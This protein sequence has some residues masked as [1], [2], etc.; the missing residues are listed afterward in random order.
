MNESNQ[1]HKGNTGRQLGIPRPED[2]QIPF[3][4][5]SSS[6]RIQS[7]PEIGGLAAILAEFDAATHSD[8]YA[9]ALRKLIRSRYNV[10]PALLVRLES[11][12]IGLAK[13]A[14]MAL[15]HM[16]SHQ[17]I[18]NLVA[19]ARDPER[20]LYEHATMALSCIDSIDAIKLL[21]GM[22]QHESIPVQAA[23]AKALGKS[24]LPAAT[25]LV[26]ALERGEDL[27]RIRAA[28]SLG[29]INS[30]LAVPSLIRALSDPIQKVR[31]EA[32]WALG[33]I[34]SPL[35]AS[36][37]A[38]RLTDADL[39]VQSQA[40]QALKNIGAPAIPAIVPMLE[41]ASSHTRSIAA[42]TLGQIGLPDAIPLL[43]AVLKNDGFP[44][45][46]CDAAAALGEIGT[47]DAVFHLAAT[48]KDG[49]RSVCNA[50]MRALRRINSPEAREV[51]KAANRS[52]AIPQYSVS[53]LEEP[54]VLSDFTVL[55]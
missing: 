49:D 5:E 8:R 14:A 47:Y 6:E 48:L 37:L 40:V 26:E 45:V 50:A 17:A 23:A 38:V 35:A 9:Q 15:G 1:P 34:R 22:L 19:V 29:Q 24:G 27:V 39:G 21:I 32:A 3:I 28:R 53:N 11:D 36:A 16:R 12:D 20:Q 18:S 52:V 2:Y 44:Y 30:P 43:V 51:L 42:R 33:Q 55:Q 4:S 41:N 54:E 46:R 31:S 7:A 10:V 25:P 13:K